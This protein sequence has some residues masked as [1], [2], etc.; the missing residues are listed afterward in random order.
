MK[1]SMYC[2][3][4]DL[5]INVSCYCYSI[6]HCNMSSSGNEL[7]IQVSK[8]YKQF[9]RGRNAQKVLKGIN[10]DVPYHSMLVMLII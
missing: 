4:N 10:M 5:F 9:G 7:A 3:C 2:L 1:H 6:F 8:V